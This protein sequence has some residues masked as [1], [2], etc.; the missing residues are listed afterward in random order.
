MHFL[1]AMELGSRADVARVE[2]HARVFSSI[3]NAYKR[4]EYCI[5][6]ACKHCRMEHWK[7]FTERHDSSR[8]QGPG[9][10]I[11]VISV[12]EIDNNV[13]AHH[14]D[15]PVLLNARDS[16]ESL[17]SCMVIISKKMGRN[18]EI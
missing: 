3:F 2:I 4:S 16:M 15:I 7:S 5:Y 18:M 11:N 17:L 14:G 1:N 10:P 13:S 12:C 9:R 8:A 6:F